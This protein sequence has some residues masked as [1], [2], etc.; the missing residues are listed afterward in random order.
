MITVDGQA[1]RVLTAYTDLVVERGLHGATLEAVARRAGLSKSGALHHFASVGALRSA[2]FVELAA[3]SAR[4]AEAM[5]AA[6]E[7]AV[8]YY[9]ASSLDR[10]SELERVIEAVYRIAQTGDETAL[11]ALRESRVAWLDALVAETGDSA[12]ARLVLFAGDG[13]NHNALMSLADGEDVLD[14]EHVEA[15]IAALEGLGTKR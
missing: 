15:L 2:L 8:R 7:G 14:R 13:M 11:A 1:A 5:R 12:L 6:P 10:D 3:Q 9:V 4:D